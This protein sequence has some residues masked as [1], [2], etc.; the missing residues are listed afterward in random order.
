LHL[1]DDGSPRVSLIYDPSSM[2][3]QEPPGVR[4]RN[5]PRRSFEDPHAKSRFQIRNRA[6]DGGLGNAKR[7]RGGR[8]AVQVDDFGQNGQ[9][10]RC[11]DRAMSILKSGTSIVSP[12]RHPGQAAGA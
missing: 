1:D 9:L 11:P 10:R 6:A 2:R 8:K 3:V 5:A 7:P 4:K 12:K